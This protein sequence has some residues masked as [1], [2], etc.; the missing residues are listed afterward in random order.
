MYLSRIHNQQGS[1]LVIALFV[2]VVLAGLGI[3]MTRMLSANIAND[4]GQRRRCSGFCLRLKPGLRS[5]CNKR[6][7]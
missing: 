1:M 3:T 6:F 7:H 5:C 4:C 2:I